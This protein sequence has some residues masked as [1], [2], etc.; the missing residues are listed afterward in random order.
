MSHLNQ[1]PSMMKTNLFTDEYT[2]VNKQQIVAAVKH[3]PYISKLIIDQKL[4]QSL[5]IYDLNLPLFQCT[6]TQTNN[7]LKLLFAELGSAN[8][9]SLFC[10]TF[11]INSICIQWANSYTTELLG[12]YK[13]L[14]FVMLAECGAEVA[15]VVFAWHL[16]ALQLIETV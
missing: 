4:K 7:L 6:T 5:N 15:G 14:Y 12:T 16:Q 3:T 11:T 13:F 10:K 8:R 1:F 2:S 9:L